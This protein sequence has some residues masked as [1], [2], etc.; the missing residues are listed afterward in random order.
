MFPMFG[1]LAGRESLM[2]SSVPVPTILS[3]IEFIHVPPDLVLTPSGTNCTDFIVHCVVMFCTSPF[4]HRLIKFEESRT[5]KAVERIHLKTSFSTLKTIID[6][7]YNGSVTL[8]GLDTARLLV[9]VD[10]FNVPG[11]TELI[12]EKITSGTPWVEKSPLDR[13]WKEKGVRFWRVE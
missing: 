6:F 4:L 2:F 10:Y 11:V 7:A 1:V 9:E 8:T 13:Y 12:K 3:G 5:G